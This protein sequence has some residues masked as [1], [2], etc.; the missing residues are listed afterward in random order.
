MKNPYFIKN[1]V[2]ETCPEQVRADL[3]LM[4]RSPTPAL[5]AGLERDAVPNRH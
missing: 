1:G 4:R 3:L 2:I 5:S